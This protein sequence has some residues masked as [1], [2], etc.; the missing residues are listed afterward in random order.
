MKRKMAGGHKHMI[1]M[2]GNIRK[3]IVIEVMIV[4]VEF[5]AAGGGRNGQHRWSCSA[6]RFEFSRRRRD[7][8]QRSLNSSGARRRL[9]QRECS[10]PDG[11]RDEDPKEGCDGGAVRPASSASATALQQPRAPN[12]HDLSLHVAACPS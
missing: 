5:I 6:A 7:P 12:R 9:T 8:S 1:L 3:L 2:A 10:R 11:Q 4:Y